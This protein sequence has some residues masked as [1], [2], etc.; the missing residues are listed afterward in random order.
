VGE[1]GRLWKVAGLEMQVWNQSDGSG[2]CRLGVG[3][4]FLVAPEGDVRPLLEDNED[5][6]E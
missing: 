1:T 4:F 2:R 6:V 3:F 5:L